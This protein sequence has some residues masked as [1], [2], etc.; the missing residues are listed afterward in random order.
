MQR[1]PVKAAEF[2]LFILHPLPTSR[3]NSKVVSHLYLKPKYL[4]ML[5]EF[6]LPECHPYRQMSIKASIAEGSDQETGGVSF[7]H[8]LVLEGCFV[9][10]WCSAWCSCGKVAHVVRGM[11][12]CIC[13]RQG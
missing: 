12:A 7:P 8:S 11:H 9:C 4:R 10:S 2:F 6:R 13:A 5:D 3:L 1:Q